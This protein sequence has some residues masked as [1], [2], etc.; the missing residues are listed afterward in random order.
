MDD[1]NRDSAEY[2]A[3]VCLTPAF[4][5]AVKTQLTSLGAQFVAIG[6]I[7]PD[8][9]CWLIIN[10]SL[11]EDDQAANLIRLIK[12]KVRQEPQCYQKFISALEKDRSQY[13]SIV[14]TLQHTVELIRQ[15]QQSNTVDATPSSTASTS[16]I[17]FPLHIHCG[18]EQ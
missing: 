1:I 6:L 14:G 18:R 3:L 4:E 15:Q 16:S 11:Q 7:T 9:C 5:L 2:R 8:D 17:Y 10:P 13:S 12:Q